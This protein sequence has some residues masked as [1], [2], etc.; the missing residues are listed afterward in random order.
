MSAASNDT[1]TMPTQGDIESAYAWWRLLTSVLLMTIAGVG[2][3]AVMVVLPTIQLEFGVDRGAAALPFTVIMLGFGFGGVFMGRLSDRYGITVPLTVAAC[4][5]CLGFALAG[6]ST[7]LGQFTAVHGVLIGFFGIS[8]TFAPLLADISH[9]FVRR[10][11][12]AVAI[13]ACGNYLAG[14]IWPPIIQHFLETVGWRQT[15]TGIGIFCVVTM[16]PLALVLRRRLAHFEESVDAAGQAGTRRSLGLSP[17]QLTALLFIAGLGCC[18]AMSMPQVHLV[19]LCSDLG[20]GA[21]RGAEMLSLMLG[22]GVISRLVFGLISDRI[23]GLR[24][25]LLGS[26]MQG[27]ALLLFLPANGLVS[28]YLVSGLFG[29]FQGG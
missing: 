28:L 6:R 23:G 12:L 24:T 13:C 29:L 7:T 9:W 14:A 1:L 2:M 8:A 16:L 22:L 5:L 3:Y 25:L 20:F 15:F 18:V 17:P 26:T 10:R 4:A 21:A 27:I 19:A 11:G